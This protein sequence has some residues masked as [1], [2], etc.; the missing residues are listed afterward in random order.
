MYI[1]MFNQIQAG[2]IKILTMT[3]EFVCTLYLSTLASV[4]DGLTT[5]CIYY[6]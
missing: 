3:R 6:S 2:S 1:N 4:F 5:H